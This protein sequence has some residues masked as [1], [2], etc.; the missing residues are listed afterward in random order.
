MKCHCQ[1]V[2]VEL[3]SAALFM[4]S[5]RTE[6]R[7]DNSLPYFLVLYFICSVVVLP[8]FGRETEDIKYE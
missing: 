5:A 2:S 6:E 7:R 8:R 1:N 4:V 3:F